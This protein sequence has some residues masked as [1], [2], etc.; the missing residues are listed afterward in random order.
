MFLGHIDMSGI[1][2]GNQHQTCQV[3][4]IFS[5]KIFSHKPMAHV[6][7]IS[8]HTLVGVRGPWREI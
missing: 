2:S 3:T 1:H 4:K 6:N 8:T 5:R 7:R